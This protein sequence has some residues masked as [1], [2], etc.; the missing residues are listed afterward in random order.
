MNCIEF[1]STIRTHVETRRP[2]D[3]AGLKEHARQC[4][5]CGQIWRDH[6]ILDRVISPWKTEVFEVDLSETILEQFSA[7]KKTGDDSRISQRVAT[8]VVPQRAELSF[9]DTRTID[10]KT[11]TTAWVIMSIIASVLVMLQMAM[12]IPDSHRGGQPAIQF[13]ADDESNQPAQ[14][15]LPNIDMLISDAGIAW[16][17]LADEAAVSVTDAAILLPAAARTNTAVETNQPERENW[18]D[19]WKQ[20]LRPIRDDVKNAVHFLIRV[21]PVES[22]SAT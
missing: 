18:I 15:D 7:S 8:L 9:M 1:E 6:Y 14:D 13:A 11:P 10:R 4:A 5:T 12:R 2:L 20:E 22:S 21:L 17:S 19:N 16:R 3:D